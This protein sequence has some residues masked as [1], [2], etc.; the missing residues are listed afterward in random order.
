MMDK[1]IALGVN[2]P[3]TDHF[4]AEELS[5]WDRC[6]GKIT[7]SNFLSFSIS[8][9]DLMGRFQHAQNEQAN[10]KSVYQDACKH[11]G[12]CEREYSKLTKTVSFHDCYLCFDLFLGLQYWFNQGQSCQEIGR[13]A[14]GYV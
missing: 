10:L 3:T 8:E 5:F 7:F 6:D 12:T 11:R 2:E 13:F 9:S 4:T 14:I 1:L